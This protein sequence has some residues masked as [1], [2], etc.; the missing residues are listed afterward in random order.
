MGRS[1]FDTNRDKE[2]RIVSVAAAIYM[3]AMAME[4]G[5]G[6][7]DGYWIW[8]CQWYCLQAASANVVVRTTPAPLMTDPVSTRPIHRIALCDGMAILRSAL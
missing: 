5:Y 1:A 4:Y 7:C 3:M 6:D 8:P 2:E